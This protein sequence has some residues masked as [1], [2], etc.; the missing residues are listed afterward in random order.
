MATINIEDLTTINKDVSGYW[1]SRT[2]SG[3]QISYSGVITAGEPC[4]IASGGIYNDDNG[5]C[6][7]CV[8][9][10][11]TEVRTLIQGTTTVYVK[12][13]ITFDENSGSSVG[14]RYVYFG[15]DGTTSRTYGEYAALP[16]PTRSGY[17]FN[18]WFDSETN[19]NGTGTQITNTTVVP[20][21]IGLNKTLYAKWTQNQQQTATP[22]ILSAQQ[23]SFPFLTQGYRVRNNDGSTATIYAEPGDSTPDVSLGSVAS[24]SQTSFQSLACQPGNCNITVYAKAQ[25]SGETMS[26]TTSVYFQ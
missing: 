4:S 7:E 6:F 9:Y 10:S 11:R 26:N 15:T 21:T 1:Q 18:G 20:S 3:F 13:Y 14:N 25:A 8:G 2:C 22:S 24:G 16:T 17:T 19:N 23:G 5:N 12:A